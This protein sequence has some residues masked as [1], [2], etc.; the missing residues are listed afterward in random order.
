MRYI[1]MNAHCKVIL[2][3]GFGQFI[4]NGFHH[5]RRKFFRGKT[6]ASANRFDAGASAFDERSDDIQ[7]KGLARGA[8]F[9]GA[10]EHCDRFQG[11]R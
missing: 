4:E 10:V 7:I 11:G 5:G 8:W 9:F 2:R 6:I 1:I 3:F